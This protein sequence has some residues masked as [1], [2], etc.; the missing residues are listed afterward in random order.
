MEKELEPYKRGECDPQKVKDLQL[1]NVELIC[2]ILDKN[3][4][5]D[6][7]KREK[8]PILKENESKGDSI[9]VRENV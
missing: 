4:E 1:T 8:T 2:G 5:W 3:L 9:Q 7:R 6:T